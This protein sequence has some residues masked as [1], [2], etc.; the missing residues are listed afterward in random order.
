MLKYYKKDGTNYNNKPSF[1][2]DHAF[3]DAYKRLKFMLL[4]AQYGL[5]D[6]DISN[7]NR[8]KQSIKQKYQVYIIAQPLKDINTLRFWKV[9]NS[10]INISIYC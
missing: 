6:M 4:M 2:T 7:S 8:P 5:K 9:C 1:K 3:L 10:I